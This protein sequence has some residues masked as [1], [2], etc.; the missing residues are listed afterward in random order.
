MKGYYGTVKFNDL[1]C[2]LEKLCSSNEKHRISITV[3]TWQD[4]DYF[5]GLCEEDG[6][7]ISEHLNFFNNKPLCKKIDNFT[8]LKLM[9]NLAK[10]IPYLTS[11]NGNYKL[12]YDIHIWIN[13]HYFCYN[14]F[15]NKYFYR[16]QN[17]FQYILYS[18]ILPEWIN[19]EMESYN[20][21]ENKSEKMNGNS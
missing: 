11:K 19:Q 9:L 6:G 10:E 15:L 4:G 3:L 17:I 7:I 13:R 21:W 18:G 1:L 8:E 14:I 5:E 16:F 20:V 2:S 12:F